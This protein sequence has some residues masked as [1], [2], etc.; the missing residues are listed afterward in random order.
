MIDW[1][2]QHLEEVIVISL[3]H[4]LDLVPGESGRFIDSGTGRDVADFLAQHAPC[5]PVVLHTTNQPAAQGMEMVLVD[6]GWHVRRVS[7]YGDM[8]WIDEVWFP[9]IRNQIVESA[10]SASPGR[11]ESPTL[12]SIAV[13]IVPL[14]TSGTDTSH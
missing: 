8:E 3:D 10:T 6:A 7:P 2:T 1:L 4:D 5:C 12:H 9:T 13:E 14:A 11:L